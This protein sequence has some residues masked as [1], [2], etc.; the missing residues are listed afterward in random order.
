[1]DKESTSDRDIEPRLALID[2]LVYRAKFDPKA[3]QQLVRVASTPIPDG[4]P[5]RYLAA[6]LADRAEMTGGL[7]GLDWET[8]SNVIRNTKEPLLKQ[9][10]SSE[11]YYTLVAH[12][13]GR[14]YALSL[15]QE[16]FP[17]FTRG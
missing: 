8:A 11:S 5:D 4:T 17:D 2:Y 3:K 15:V 13:A 1:L 10:M 6:S 12:G 7:A 16:A 14:D 9:L